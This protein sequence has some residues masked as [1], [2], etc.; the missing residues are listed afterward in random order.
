MY[1]LRSF[2][3]WPEGDAVGI[4]VASVIEDPQYSGLRIL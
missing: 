3:A 2:F 4:E 1:T